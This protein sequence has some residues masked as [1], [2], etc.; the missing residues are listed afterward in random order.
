M[1]KI[2]LKSRAK[3]NLTLEIIKKLPSGFHELRSV[4]LKAENLYDEVVID[5]LKNSKKI[6]IECDND[7]IP[8]NEKNICWKIAEKFFERTGKRIGLKIKIKKKIPVMAGL[9]GGSSNGAAV[10]LSLNKH[11]KNTLSKNEL[12]N[13][14][15]QI[16]KDIPFFLEKERVAYITGEGE[17]IKPLKHFPGLSLLIINPKGEISTKEAYLELDKK[18]WFMADKKRKNIS[19]N[20][21]DKSGKSQDI[22]NFLYNDFEITAEEKFPV[23]KE[24]KNCLISFGALGASLTGKGPTIFG[25][26]KNKNETLKIKKVLKNKYPDFFIELG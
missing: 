21:V 4:M 26:F 2:K 8:K 1:K 23:I 20:L 16:G 11:F 10:L 9:G 18:M 19:Q 22:A 7:I 13:I 25:I 24:L 6:E 17:K 3:I 15:A 12:I 5:F 14:A